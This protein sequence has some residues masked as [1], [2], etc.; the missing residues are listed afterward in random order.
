MDPTQDKTKN[1]E[2]LEDCQQ[3]GEIFKVSS[4][5]RK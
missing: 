2:V 1:I 3:S 5:I 4:L